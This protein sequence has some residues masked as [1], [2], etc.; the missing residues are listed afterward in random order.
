MQQEIGASLQVQ[1]GGGV[2]WCK[3][4]DKLT[5]AMKQHV[6]DRQTWGYSIALIDKGQLAQLIPYATPGEIGAANFADQEG[7]VDPVAAAETLIAKA[8]EFGA[9]V[10]YPCEVKEIETS[11]GRVRGVL[12]SQGLME[13]DCVVLATGNATMMLAAQAGINV[14]LKESKGILAH[15]RPRTHFLSRVLMPPGC[16]VKQNPDGRIVTGTNFGD[17]GGTQAT[18]ELGR[19]YL[20][21]AA[22]YLPLCQ[23]AEVDYMTLG[24]RVMPK[25]EYP[26]IG[27]SAKLPN[28]YVAAMHSGMT[29]APIVGQLASLE[30]LDQVTVD[31]LQPYRMERF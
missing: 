17:T 14:P 5:E 23:G 18:K 8:R 25:D 12:T 24:Y 30:I 16:D 10:V 28:L 6:H 13:A 21:A 26:I 22:Q 11:A 15:S 27:R 31:V 3:P 29:M 19:A 7:T 2:Q 1:W 9:E 4:E 20:E